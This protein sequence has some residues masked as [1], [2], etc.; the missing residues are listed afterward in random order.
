MQNI[1]HVYNKISGGGEE[2]KYIGEI[3]NGSS[4][5]RQAFRPLVKAYVVLVGITFRVIGVSKY[6]ATCVLISVSE[7]FTF[8]SHKQETLR[9]VLNASNSFSNINPKKSN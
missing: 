5:T 3:V 4:D 7:L 1:L 2:C 6:L 9:S 8:G